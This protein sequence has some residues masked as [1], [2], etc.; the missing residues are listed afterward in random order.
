MARRF[1]SKHARIRWTANHANT[2]QVT[3]A[4]SL[5]AAP[6]GW[7]MNLAPI[8]TL[9]RLTNLFMEQT[10]DTTNLYVMVFATSETTDMH[11]DVFAWVNHS[12]AK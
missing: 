3:L 4:H 12:I 7:A 2:G 6:D 5:G 8:A 1:Q 11:A 10:P 9:T